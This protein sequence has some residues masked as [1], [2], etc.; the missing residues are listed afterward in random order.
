MEYYHVRV[1]QKSDRSHD[2]VRL[3]LT[4]EELEGRFLAPYCRGLPIIIGGKSIHNDDIERIRITKT[5]Q[6]SSHLAKV[7]EEERRPPGR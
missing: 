6:D 4:R 1:T 2:E 5:D 3:D 7:V